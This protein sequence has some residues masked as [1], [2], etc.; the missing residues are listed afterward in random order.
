MHKLLTIVV[1]AVVLGGCAITTPIERAESICNRLGD[2]SPACKERQFNIERAREDAFR[3]SASR[4]KPNGGMPVTPKSKD[5]D[6]QSSPSEQSTE[7]EYD[8]MNREFKENCGDRGGHYTPNLSG[9]GGGC[10]LK[11]AS[12]GQK[13][14][15]WGLY[16]LQP[17][18]GRLNGEVFRIKG[19]SLKIQRSPFSLREKVGMRGLISIT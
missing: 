17:N 16:T 10:V 7:S 2:P 14:P 13:K 12:T 18:Q 4:Q 9:V 8:R 3:N 19:V 6:K 5:A 1:G 11:E 15:G